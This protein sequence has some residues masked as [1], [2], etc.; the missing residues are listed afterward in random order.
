MALLLSFLRAAWLW[1]RGPSDKAEQ[2]EDDEDDE[3][4]EDEE[5][6]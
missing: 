4:D 5:E 2:D 3:A 6:L 1:S